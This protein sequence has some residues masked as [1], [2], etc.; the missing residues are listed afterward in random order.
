MMSK[1]QFTPLKVGFDFD[2]VIAYNPLR[3]IRPLMSF[4]K[5]K[6]MVKRD[7]LVFFQP[8]NK[9]EEFGW[10]LVHQSSFMPARGF[11]I[12]KELTQAGFI[13]PHLLTGRT[14]SLTKDLNYKLNLFGLGDLFKTVNITKHNEQPHVFKSRLLNKYQLDMFVEDNFDIVQYLKLH[15]LQTKVVWITNSLDKHIEYEQKFDSFQ[16]F[17]LKLQIDIL[18]KNKKGLA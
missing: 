13:E 9:L 3:I 12:L 2:G 10:W 5:L 16:A 14:T 6:K 1:N 15:N 18:E 17:L 7:Q 8:S 4:L 11:H